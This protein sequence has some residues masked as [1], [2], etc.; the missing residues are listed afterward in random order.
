MLNLEKQI[1]RQIEKANKILILFPH[2]KE[3]D[4]L[5][6]SLSFYLILQKLGKKVNIVKVKKNK[7]VSYSEKSLNFLPKFQEINK[8][9]K[10]L[11]NFIVS[12]NIKDTKINKI[13]YTI[14]ND[15]LNFIISPEV[16]SLSSEDLQLVSGEFNYDLIIN[17]AIHDLN[18][19]GKN[20][21]ENVEFFYKTT[22]INIDNSS[23]N[24]DY[25]QINFIDLNSI[26]ISE[27]AY[28]LIK[29]YKN[30]IITEDIATC[31]LAGIIKK[32]NNFKT[33]NLNPKTLLASSELISLGA[34]REEI[35]KNLFYSKDI[36]S[37]KLWGEVLKNLKSANSGEVVW[38]KI[39]QDYLN[40]FPVNKELLDGIVDELISSLPKAKIFYVLINRQ[41]KI[42]INAFSLKEVS[43]FNLLKEF[44]P[45]GNDLFAVAQLDKDFTKASELI[46]YLKNS[47]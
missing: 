42:E 18:S 15:Y 19:L 13:K 20:Y 40:D 37:L 21:E 23:V 29:N 10:N 25:G 30:S 47:S 36:S 28:H 7:D 3:E 12:L 35:I 1:Y 5:A 26:S 31:L 6:A 4:P 38:S 16:G 22:I 39:N 8:D 45:S 46:D 44:N 32:T 41:G 14:D 2:T 34:R 17:F 27:I 24:E 33:K 11:R 43:A 9:L